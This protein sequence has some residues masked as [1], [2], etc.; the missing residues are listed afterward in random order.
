MLYMHES[1]ILSM[2]MLTCGRHRRMISLSP[3]STFVSQTTALTVFLWGR[4]QTA[5]A[6]LGAG[7][8]S[9]WRDSAWGC[10]LRTTRGG[11]GESVI[12]S[13]RSAN[14]ALNG[15]QQTFFDES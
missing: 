5:Q 13:L 2:I 1:Y 7:S 11:A 12:Q 14:P 8:D 15:G 10:W 4:G 3:A 9:P 6:A